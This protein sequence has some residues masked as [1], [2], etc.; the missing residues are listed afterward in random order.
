MQTPYASVYSKDPFKD[1]FE[2]IENMSMQLK[3][4]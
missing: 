3:V 1:S 4:A 2:D